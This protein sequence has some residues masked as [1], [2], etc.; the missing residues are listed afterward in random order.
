MLSNEIQTHEPQLFKV[1]THTNCLYF[2]NNN[3]R[4][5]VENRSRSHEFE[6]QRVLGFFCSVYPFNTVFAA[7]VVAQSLNHHELSFPKEV[8]LS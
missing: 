1:T 7:A 4:T 2:R 6:S 3:C 5:A 8:Q